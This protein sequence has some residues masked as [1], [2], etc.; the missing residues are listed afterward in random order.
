VT[1]R[2][3][4][5]LE[6]IAA[7]GSAHPDVLVGAGTILDRAALEGAIA[8]GAAFGVSPGFD[9]E[10]SAGAA[11]AELPYVPGAATATEVQA[12]VRAGHRLVKFFP[13]EAAGG[14]ATVRALGAPFAFTGLRFMAT[15]GI[16]ADNAAAW[17]AE[18]LIAAV[19]GSWVARERDLL[20][21]AWEAISERARAAAALAAARRPG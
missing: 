3:A 10:L 15:G 14:I 2:T 4:A 19:G 16:G 7:I 21:G 18:P 9:A 6:A 17:L 20:E 11:E 8:A 5:G 1:L 13:A 12:A